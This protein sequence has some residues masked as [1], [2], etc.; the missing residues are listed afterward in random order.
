[1]WKGKYQFLLLV[2]Q[3]EEI[4][5]YDGLTWYYWLSAH[6]ELRQRKIKVKGNLAGIKPSGFTQLYEPFGAV[7]PESALPGDTRT[8]CR[9]SLPLPHSR[10]P[11]PPRC[12]HKTSAAGP[13][14]CCPRFWAEDCGPET[15]VGEET[16]CLG[17]RWGTGN[18]PHLNMRV[19]LLSCVLCWFPEKHLCQLGC[20]YRV[21]EQCKC[22]LYRLNDVTICHLLHANFTQTHSNSADWSSNCK[23]SKH[24]AV[25]VWILTWIVCLLSPPN[26]PTACF[27]TNGF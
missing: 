16:S 8:G 5:T 19:E 7:H 2:F 14:S 12:G 13:R 9:A 18:L 11:L 24:W 15:P 1:M 25:C 21:C 4:D 23:V 6:A 20:T 3:Q 26:P 10:F 17:T 22:L 27:L